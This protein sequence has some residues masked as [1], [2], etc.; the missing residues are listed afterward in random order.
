M[1]ILLAMEAIEKWSSGTRCIS[2]MPRLTTM[3][4]LDR[5]AILPNAAGTIAWVP[6]PEQLKRQEN[7][8]YTCHNGVAKEEPVSKSPQLMQAILLWD[9]CP[10]M[11]TVNPVFHNQSSVPPTAAKTEERAPLP[12]Q[13]EQQKDWDYTCLLD[14]W[15]PST[16]CAS[17]AVPLPAQAPMEICNVMSLATDSL[18][19]DLSSKRQWQEEPEPPENNVE[20]ADKW[21]PK[22]SKVGKVEVPVAKGGRTFEIPLIVQ[23]ML[24]QNSSPGID[25]S[26]HIVWKQC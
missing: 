5:S 26:N 3:D 15:K 25:I 19:L 24:S 12:E 17:S 13:L 8:N 9:H 20:E 14:K 11:P 22:T 16:N 1:Q 18:T 2:N 21:L 23:T 10:K 7:M 6:L 4:H